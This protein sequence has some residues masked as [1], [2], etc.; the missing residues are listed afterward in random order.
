MIKIKKSEK[1]S[2]IVPVYNNERTIERC[3]KSLLKQTYTNFEIIII[4]DG[5]TDNTK[6]IIKKFQ[7]NKKIY[8]FDQP[9]RGVSCARNLGLKKS[10]GKYISFVDSD[11]YVENNFLQDLIDGMKDINDLSIVGLRHKY[12]NND[13]IDKIEKYYEGE[14]TS[15]QVL[16]FL[17]FKNGPQGYLPNKLWRKDIIYKNGL[18]LDPEL[19]K[20]EDL[21]FTVKYLL[22]SK[23]VSIKNHIDYVYVHENF[24]LTSEM[25]FT[26]KPPKYIPTYETML[27]SVTQIL[28][29]ISRRGSRENEK[30][31]LVFLGMLCSGYIRHLL[32][33]GKILKNPDNRRKYKK[34][35]KKMW[36]LRKIVSKNQYLDNKQRIIYLCTLY[37][38]L[39]MKLIDD[40]RKNRN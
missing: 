35:R 31:A 24:S 30:A 10:K 20:L 25:S 6:E 33:Y 27:N 21:L 12:P 38:P 16:N 34:L 7:N 5:S 28:K 2:V 8:I 40:I 18:F 22:S 15:T 26:R 4:N 32:V 9:N 19:D 1:I 17:F 11:D 36:R 37:T 29:Y 3:I 14:F 13:K 39:I 23:N